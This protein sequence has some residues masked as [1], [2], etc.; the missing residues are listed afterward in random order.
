MKRRLLIPLLLCLLAGLCMLLCA[1]NILDLFLPKVTTAQA[2]TTPASTSGNEPGEWSITYINAGQNGKNP[3][4]Y[5]AETL[6]ITLQSPEKE[7]YDFA[8]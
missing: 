2:A 5:S 4:T 8:G 6:P 3:V 7:G 1:C